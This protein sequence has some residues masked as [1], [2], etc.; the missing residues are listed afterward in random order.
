[1]ADTLPTLVVG[2]G[3]AGL[4]AGVALAR[5]GSPCLLAE[6]ESAA[7]GM[8][9]SVVMDGVTFDLGPHVAFP[10]ATPAGR[11]IGEALSRIETLSRPFAFS[12]FA[13]GRHWR[14]P[15]HF[16][17]LRYPWRFKL[18]TVRTLLA[19]TGRIESAADELRARTGSL[20]YDQLFRDT[21][22][23]KSG[24]DPESVHRHWLM[25]PDRTVDN[26]LEPPPVRSR[27]GVIRTALDR[28]RRRY[29]YPRQ[30][31][32]ALPAE[33]HAMFTESGGRTEL[34]CGPIALEVSGG[35][36][37]GAVI[38]G[39]RIPVGDVIWTAPQDRLGDALS[40]PVEALPGADIL[41]VLAT[42]D[43]PRPEPRPFVYTYHPDPVLIFNRV[44]YPAA[45][46]PGLHAGRE[47]LCLEITVESDATDSACAVLAERAVA[48]VGRLGLH[49]P[50][51]L[52][53]LRTVRLRRALPVY[54]LDYEA[55]L[56]SAYAPV[57]AL[58]NLVAV[59]RQGGWFFCMSTGAVSQGLKAAAE[60]LRRREGSR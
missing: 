18:D 26:R 35:A 6:A 4:A 24:K 30:G 13:A 48:D 58:R 34:G 53:A 50:A 47:G 2:A 15:N 20:V 22:R 28:L 12:V 19:K 46:L 52:R 29:I 10:D 45:V 51:R 5:R 43:G 14:F 38:R 40:H 23:K 37:T 21:L 57:R 32:G 31:F 25:R 55:R 56:E 3:L 16:D 39:E 1:M 36:V 49:D 8:A 7:G 27:T 41:L 42:W 33:M 9:R 44:S 17:W 54:P 11:L 59:G 60:T